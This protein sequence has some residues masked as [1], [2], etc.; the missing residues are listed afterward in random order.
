M[1]ELHDLP[2]VDGLVDSDFGDQFLPRPAFHQSAFGNYL[3][4]QDVDAVLEVDHFV[5]FG[6]PAFTEQF[7]LLVFFNY[8]FSVVFADFFDNQI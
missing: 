5:A 6:E 8:Y 2:V 1:L 4:S 7:S 3:G